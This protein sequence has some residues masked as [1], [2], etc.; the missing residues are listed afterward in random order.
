MERGSTQKS[1][2]IMGEATVLEFLFAP[3]QKFQHRASPIILRLF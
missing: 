2:K 3:L 1:L